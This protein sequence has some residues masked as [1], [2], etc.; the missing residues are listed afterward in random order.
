MLEKTMVVKDSSF[1][2]L[3]DPFE[4][5]KSRKYVFYVKVDDVAEGIPM[6]TNPRDQKLT[7]N[8]AKAIT[9]SLTSNDGYFHLKNR[10]IVVSAQKVNYNNKTGK[11]TIYFE[12]TQYHGNI[13]GG[14]TYKIVCD[15][16]GENL[17]Q[18]V[19]FEI[20][21]GVE[22][23]IENLA[24]ARNTSVQ[25]D[26]KSM[27]ELAQKFDPIKEALEGMPFYRRIAFRQ[28][29]SSVDE[30]TG[31]NEKMIDA[32]EVVA[33]INMFNVDKFTG[34]NHPIQAYS[35]KAK[36]LSIYL[37]DVESYRKYVNIIPDIFDL[38]DGIE[39]EFAKAYNE[40]GGKYG[41]KKYS[42]FKDGNVIA[43]SKFGLH[44]LQYK[45]PDGIMYPVVAAFRSLVK[46]NESTGKYEWNSGVNPLKIWDKCKTELASK[47]MSFASSIGDNP[48]AVGKDQ[49]VW[50]LAYMTVLLNKSN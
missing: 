48:N 45:I 6:T 50:D 35:S 43:K 28:N 27:A 37:S 8:V 30:E 20:M 12:N 39:Q 5:G 46:F 25:V 4:N 18:Y 11:V 33:I 17:D 14:H 3:D 9:D 13:D 22:D 21:T 24:E 26:E 44:E 49:N 31:R 36:M 16:K 1:R 19:Q 23:I 38:Y 47:V 34:S 7:S 42:G 2:K 40:A 15:H 41:R 10:G 32:R 29:Q